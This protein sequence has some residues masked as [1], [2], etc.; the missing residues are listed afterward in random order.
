MASVLSPSSGRRVACKDRDQLNSTKHV[1]ETSAPVALAIILRRVTRKFSGRGRNPPADKGQEVVMHQA[2]YPRDLCL[3]KPRHHCTVAAIHC[4]A[5][6]GG[7]AEATHLK[8][9][10]AREGACGTEHHRARGGRDR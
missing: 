4:R 9:K 2:H 10:D 6:A 8:L 3:L 1:L 7:I 5:V